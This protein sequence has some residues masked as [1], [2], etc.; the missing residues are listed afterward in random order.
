MRLAV[1]PGI[2]NVDGRRA[3]PADRAGR[4]LRELA[5]GAVD[6]HLRDADRLGAVGANGERDQAGGQ[7]RRLDGDLLDRRGGSRELVERLREEQRCEDRREHQERQQQPEDGPRRHACGR[8]AHPAAPGGGIDHLEMAHPAELGELRLVRVEHVDAGL[9]V[10]EGELEDAALALAL[11]D[12]VDG[13]QRRRQRR[14]VIVIVEE[15]GVQVE[16]VDRVEL[17]DVDEVDAHRPRPLDADRLVDVGEGDGV[18]GVDLVLLVEVRVEA[19]HHH[20][21]LLP[22]GILRRAEQARSARRR[23]PPD[24]APGRDR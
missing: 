11:H 12:G 5:V 24:A 19:V 17:G 9:V 7:P 6:L 21:E 14:A 18:D 16:R 1:E 22:A 15:V 2:G 23:P 13:P 8:R 3:E 10:G 4:I 20:H